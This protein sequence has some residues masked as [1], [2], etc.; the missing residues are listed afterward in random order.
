MANLRIPIAVRLLA[1]FA[2]ILAVMVWTSQAT[3]ASFAII[4][5]DVQ[6]KLRDDSIPGLAQIARIGNSVAT[7]RGDIWRHCFTRDAETLA[8]LERQIAGERSD[9]LREMGDYEKTITRDEDRRLFNDLRAAMTPYLGMYDSILALSRQND[10]AAVT[11][12]LREAGQIYEGTIKPLL[13]TLIDKNIAW[14]TETVNEVVAETEQ[15]RSDAWRGAALAVALGLA[16]AA[17]LT[18]HL[19]RP[20][21]RC[22]AVID[23]LAQGRTDDGLDEAQRRALTGRSDELGAIARSV[24]DM[25]GY[26]DGMAGAAQAIATGDLTAT[27]APRGGDDRLGTAFAAMI[28]HLRHDIEVLGRSAQTIAAAADEL[29]AVSS[30]LSTGAEEAAAQ[31]TSASA[32]GEQVHRNVQTVAAGAEEMGTSIK[33]IAGNASTVAD[34]IRQAAQ[35]AEQLATASQD[36]DRIVRTIGEVANRT[37]LLALNASIEAANAGEAGRGFAV[38]AGEVKT[39][40]EQSRQAAAQAADILGRMREHAG[41]VDAATRE[42]RG[43]VDSVASAVEQQ[44]STTGEIGRSMG[45]AAKATA[46]IAGNLAQ[47]SRAAE[48]TTAGVGQLR[49]SAGALARMAGELKTVV[50]RFR[51]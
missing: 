12:R 45:E 9:L 37:N 27:I 32:A 38:V 11:V 36:V 4:G 14:G 34:R 20:L 35:A 46:E 49:Q 41:K 31:S 13:H 28:T 21:S 18:W 3:I 33:E 17:A 2:L 44:S 51:V 16:V 50:E 22:T 47:V 23:R 24:Q 40:A 39:L 10:D 7:V 25:C 26:L 30:Q 43:A 42:V 5:H 48:E 19:V 15:A 8:R 6:A 29:S 1:A